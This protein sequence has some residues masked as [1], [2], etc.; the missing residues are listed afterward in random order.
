MLFL[1]LSVVSGLALLLV[2]GKLLLSS[3]GV[4]SAGGQRLPLT[5]LEKRAW[6]GLGLGAAWLF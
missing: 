6:I 1:V 2:A 4:G 3:R 5:P